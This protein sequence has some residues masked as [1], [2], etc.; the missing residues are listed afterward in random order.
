MLNHL[1]GKWLPLCGA[2]AVLALDQLTKFWVTS[3]IPVGGLGFTWGG[4][5]F[6]LVHS[7]NTGILLSLGAA[8]P[9]W[10]RITVFSVVPGLLLAAGAWYFWQETRLV[11]LQR[12]GL[13]LLL[14]GGLGNETDRLFRPEGV[15]DFLS[16]N[17]YGWFGWQRFATFNLADLAM[18]VGVLLVL[19]SWLKPFR[20]HQNNQ[21]EAP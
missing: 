2:L 4:D 17:L 12:W 7:R 15:V 9:E 10:A 19:A 16:F 14:A 5:F 11:R 3:L 1:Q 8:W 20:P 18:T 21:G 13:A 6:W